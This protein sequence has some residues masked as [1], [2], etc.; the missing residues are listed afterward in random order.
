MKKVIIGVDAGGTKTKVAAIDENKQIVY[1]AIGG[2]GSPAVLLNQA[3]N[4]IV[5]K[6]FEVY[7]KVKDEYHVSY[8]QMG[9]SGFGTLVNAHEK[10]LELSEKLNVEVSM[11]SDTDLG[12][13]SIIEDKSDEGILVLSGTGSA[14]AGINK[15]KTMLVGGYGALLTESGSSYASVKMLV[16]NIIEKYEEDLS[17]SELGNEFMELIGADSVAY[18]RKFMYRNV[19]TD[20]ASYS[21][22]ISQKALEGNQEAISILKK[23]GRDLANSVRKVYKN[24]KLCEKAVMGFRGSFIQKAPYVQD[25][26]KKA[27][28]EY[29]VKIKINEKDEDPVF[30]AYYMA[31]RKGKI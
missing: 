3:Y 27:L 22:F 30:G 7:D 18:F 20:I 9:I 1:E 10:E 28:N 26:L 23:C 19:K 21:K 12:L 17:F 2:P 6:L 24:L 31:K 4:N 16:V 29:G 8:I 25:E 11:T 13:Y 14:I 5:E 15:D